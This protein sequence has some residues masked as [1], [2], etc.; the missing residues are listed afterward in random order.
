MLNAFYNPFF[1]LDTVCVSIAAGHGYSRLNDIAVVHVAER[2]SEIFT[3]SPT[4][5]SPCLSIL[6]FSSRINM[7]SFCM[8]M[9]YKYICFA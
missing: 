1:G 6:N 3:L 7:P 4:W 8:N 5:I 2:N 9:Q